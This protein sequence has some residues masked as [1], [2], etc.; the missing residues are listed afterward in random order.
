MDAVLPFPGTPCAAV[1]K[2]ERERERE[3]KK[4]VRK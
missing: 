4:K 3:K 1:L 2:G